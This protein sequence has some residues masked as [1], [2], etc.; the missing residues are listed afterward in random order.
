MIVNS[1]AIHWQ[2]RP[3]HRNRKEQRLPAPSSFDFEGTWEAEWEKNL[4]EMAV[5]R[6]KAQVSPKH[7]QIFDLYV[8]K[9]WSVREV[10]RALGVSV[11]LIYVAKH[12][13]ARR[14]K[15]ELKLLKANP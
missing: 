9:E 11:S 15:A 5:A 13:I 2:R 1:D 12:R 14:I 4:W 7:F 10:A 6:V 3:A 8:R